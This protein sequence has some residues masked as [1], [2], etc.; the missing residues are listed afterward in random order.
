VQAREGTVVE[1]APNLDRVV[2][3]N[4]NS[5]LWLNMSPC[6]MSSLF[7]TMQGPSVMQSVHDIDNILHY[8]IGNPGNEGRMR[9][10]LEVWK[11]NFI[12][13]SFCC[14][15]KHL[16]NFIFIVVFLAEVAKAPS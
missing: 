13:D 2:S 8:P 6:Y 1:I 7:C 3:T 14:N 11:C 15:Y 10:T 4:F 9:E 12:Y 16:L 5:I